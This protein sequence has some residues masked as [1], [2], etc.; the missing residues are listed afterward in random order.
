M[1]QPTFQLA[2]SS[3]VI[4]I[5]CSCIVS[6][7]QALTPSMPELGGVMAFPPLTPAMG[8]PNQPIE[9]T[10]LMPA[11]GGDPN[12]TIRRDPFWPVGYAPKK[13]VVA[14]ILPPA[15]KT[16]VAADPVY[17][18]PP[19]WNVARNRLDI[20]GISLIGR[21]KKS[22]APKYLAMIGEKL[23]EEG[24]TVSIIADN[25]TYRWKVAGISANGISLVK[26]DVR[27]E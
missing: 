26:T 7:Q 3:M 14:T 13:T 22:N 23:V 18:S 21:D 9:E 12:L 10:G 25:R 1:R 6:G 24:D 5:S 27:P 11:N 8:M 19:D 2:A 15:T 16:P 17:L 20:R 4:L